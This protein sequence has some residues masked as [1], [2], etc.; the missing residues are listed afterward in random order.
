MTFRMKLH[1]GPY[2]TPRVRIGRT[3]L[4]DEARGIEVVVVGV[5][6]ARI[7]WP[8]GKL[9]DGRAKSLIVY[10]DLERAVRL[11]SNLAVCHWFSVTPQT[12]TKWRKAL[13]VPRMTARESWP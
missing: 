12:V 7:P 5:T 13:T 2:S 1:H 4:M 11:E 9:G 3:V 6:S 10:G 8:I